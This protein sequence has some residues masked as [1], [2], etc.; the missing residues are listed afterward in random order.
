MKRKYVVDNSWSQVD[1]G[2]RYLV[3]GPGGSITIDESRRGKLEGF[4]RPGYKGDD[5]EAV[6]G[7]IRCIREYGESRVDED[8]EGNA[9][10]MER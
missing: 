8:D 3:T 7:A 5:S 6:N 1:G 10:F 9:Y 2:T 4:A